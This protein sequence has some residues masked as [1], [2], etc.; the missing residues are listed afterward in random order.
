MPYARTLDSA[1]LEVHRVLMAD[2][3]ILPITEVAIRNKCYIMNKDAS[4]DVVALK[5]ELKDFQVKIA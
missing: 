3:T 5:G 2:V 4:E 1:T